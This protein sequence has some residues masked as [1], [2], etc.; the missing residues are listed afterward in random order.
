MFACWVI[1]PLLLVP[2]LRGL[3]HLGQAEDWQLGEAALETP[4]GQLPRPGWGFSDGGT[5]R[6]GLLTRKRE[7]GS[8][9]Q[10][11]SMSVWSNWSLP[12]VRICTRHHSIKQVTLLPPS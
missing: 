3:R 10:N 12:G 5:V 4:V 1:V 6:G 9:W 11:G 2:L 7:A 8:G